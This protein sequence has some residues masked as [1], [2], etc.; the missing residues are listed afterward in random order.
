[1]NVLIRP[2]IKTLSNTLISNNLCS[3]W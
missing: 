3:A 2:A 1:M